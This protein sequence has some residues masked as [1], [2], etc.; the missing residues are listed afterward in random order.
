MLG[1]NFVKKEYLSHTYP[2][3]ISYVVIVAY[4]IKRDES[5]GVSL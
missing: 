2:G 1:N 3:S 5:R 4:D